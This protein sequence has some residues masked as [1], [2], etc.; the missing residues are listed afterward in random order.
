MY[1]SLQH[2][3]RKKRQFRREDQNEY[4]QKQ[5]KKTDSSEAISISSA[6]WTLNRVL[7]KQRTSSFVLIGVKSLHLTRWSLHD[8]KP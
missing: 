1:H 6:A 2:Q 3:E 5:K 7:S 8:E 4:N